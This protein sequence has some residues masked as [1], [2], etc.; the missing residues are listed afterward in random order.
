MTSGG[1]TD[2]HTPSPPPSV[3]LKP[4]AAEKPGSREMP[5][6]GRVCLPA[7]SKGPL[8]L[9]ADT[10][11]LLA[12]HAPLARAPAPVRWALSA[13]GGSHTHK[14]QL[15][16]TQDHLLPLRPWAGALERTC[17]GPGTQGRNSG[18]GTQVGL[19]SGDLSLA[20]RKTHT[21]GDA[22][23][24]TTLHFLLPGPCE[25]GRPRAASKG[26]WASAARRPSPR[27]APAAST[28]QGYQ[29]VL[30]R[31]H[32][33]HRER[34]ARLASTRPRQRVLGLKCHTQNTGGKAR[35]PPNS[36]VTQVVPSFTP[37]TSQGL[38]WGW[39][40][41]STPPGAA[42]KAGRGFPIPGQDCN[43]RRGAAGFPPDPDAAHPTLAGTVQTPCEG[44][45]G[46]GRSLWLV[47]GLRNL[48]PGRDGQAAPLRQISRAGPSGWAWNSRGHTGMRGPAGSPSSLCRDTRLWPESRPGGWRKQR[49]AARWNH[50]RAGQVL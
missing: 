22:E 3:L 29:G 45:G 39:G 6:R 23:R 33:Q 2:A 25:V 19:T 18:R 7:Q 11:R 24:A 28:K 30:G 10:P 14:R 40:G 27:P 37:V 20:G 34:G 31:S 46:A 35:A 42:G 36:A 47:P 16:P 32:L 21:P 48:R 1:Q 17:T 43:P 38:W 15:G 9:V 4:R 49:T 26:S 41:P 5:T 50:D 8:S 13:T 44:Q 12:P